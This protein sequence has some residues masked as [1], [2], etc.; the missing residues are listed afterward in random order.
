MSKEPADPK[1]QPQRSTF[2]LLLVLAILL[3]G[4]CA[5]I[6]WRPVFQSPHI[7]IVGELPS[8]ARLINHEL[9]RAGIDYSHVFEFSCSDTTLRDRLVNKWQLRDLTGSEEAP[10]SFVEIRRPSWG[11]ST[12]PPEERKFGR[13]DQAREEYWSVWE[14]SQAGRLYVEVGRW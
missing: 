14:D 5:F 13:E 7:R 6:L 1:R 4:V 12:V 9:I 11:P 10:T 2:P 8:S 3:L